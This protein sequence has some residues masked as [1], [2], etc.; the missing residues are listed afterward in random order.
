M[1]ELLRAL[2]VRAHRKGVVGLGKILAT[3]AVLLRE[4]LLQLERLILAVGDEE[5]V[6][7]LDRIE[8]FGEQVRAAQRLERVE[9]SRVRA[10]H[11]PPHHRHAHEL[12][13]VGLALQPALQV[14]LERVAMRA[15][16]P[17]DFH[18]LHFARCHAR[19]LHRHEGIV[20]HPGLPAAAR[21]LRVLRERREP[22]EGQIAAALATVLLAAVARRFLSRRR[23]L[24]LVLGSRC[25]GLRGRALLPSGGLGLLWGSGGGALRRWRSAPTGADAQ[26]EQSCQNGRSGHG[27]TFISA[28]LA[29]RKLHRGSLQVS[30]AWR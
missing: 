14:R 19:G 28:C 9:E 10:V 4:S 30:D 18:H 13:V 7:L 1:R 25:G 21:Q 2:Q 24:G 3:D 15:A 8:R 16:E 11:W 17:E 27:D 12:D 5:T 22:L 26:R 6:L 29:R 20:V 23:L